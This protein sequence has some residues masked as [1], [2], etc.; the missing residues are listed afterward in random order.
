M[1]GCVNNRD[2]GDLRRYCVHYDVTVM[3]TLHHDD[4][5]MIAQWANIRVRVHVHD[6]PYHLQ[7]P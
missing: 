7:T 3:T 4:I 5:E 1:N 6:I 2:A